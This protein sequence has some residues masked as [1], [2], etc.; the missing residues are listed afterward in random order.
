MKLE[1]DKK[2]LLSF[3][4]F[5]IIAFFFWT[6]TI[7]TRQHINAKTIWLELNPPESMVLLDDNLI[8]G[9]LK[10][11]G[12]GFNLLTVPSFSKRKPLKIYLEDDEEAISKDKVGMLLNLYIKNPNIIIEEI[13]FPPLKVHMAPRSS[14]KVPVHLNAE[15]DYEKYFGPKEVVRIVPDSIV[16]SGPD[17]LIESI[18]R[19]ETELVKFNKLRTSVNAV[20]ELVALPEFF[21]GS[22]KDVKLEIPV[23]NY[24]EKRISVPVIVQ[25]NDN[26]QFISS[27]AEIEVSFLVG[28]SRHDLIEAEDFT[29]AIF[30]TTESQR[31]EKNPVII[32][33]KP[34]DISIQFIKPAF[35]DVLPKK[36]ANKK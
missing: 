21:V 27:P 1:I 14:K 9:K 29:A 6:G 16:I 13:L 3:I 30:I 11:S 22:T 2:I 19:W 23:E 20:I 18:A 25:G 26:E 35:V 32:L 17:S 12:I 10:L 31:I 15:I 5:V 4:P 24:T 36:K 28:L 7:L 8:E 33:N 34:D